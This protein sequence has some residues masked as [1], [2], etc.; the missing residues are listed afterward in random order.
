ME[1]VTMFVSLVLQCNLK[2]KKNQLHDIINIFVIYIKNIN[3][4]KFKKG[5]TIHFSRN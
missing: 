5:R 2:S 1:K 3:Y 4:L